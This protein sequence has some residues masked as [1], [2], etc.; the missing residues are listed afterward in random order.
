MARQPG[1]VVERQ[2]VRAQIEA[3]KVEVDAWLKKVADML[4]EGVSTDA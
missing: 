1:L 2:E 3:H 4:N